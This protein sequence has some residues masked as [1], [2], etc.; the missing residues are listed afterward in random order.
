VWL[1][2]HLP[3]YRFAGYGE[4]AADGRRHVP[5]RRLVLAALVSYVL[6]RWRC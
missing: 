1:Q 3:G 6:M 5:R 2:R 4:L